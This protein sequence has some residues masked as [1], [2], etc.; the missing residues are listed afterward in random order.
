MVVIVGCAGCSGWVNGW[1]ETC[2]YKRNGTLR[3]ASSG[4]CEGRDSFKA[5][6]ESG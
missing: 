2:K 3:E 1:M 5:G 4:L 6:I